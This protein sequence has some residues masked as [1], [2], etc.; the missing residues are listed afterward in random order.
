MG[1]CCN[2]QIIVPFIQ[3]ISSCSICIIRSQFSSIYCHIQRLRCSRCKDFCFSKSTQCNGRFFYTILNVICCIWRLEVNLNSFFSRILF[4]CICYFYR[5][6]KYI[7]FF[8][9]RNFQITVFKIGITH[10]ISEW[11]CHVIM[12]FVR[13]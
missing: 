9:V 12:I 6:F 8:V 3:N 13:T 10:T 2:C 1:I 11:I 4:S 5:D 7:F